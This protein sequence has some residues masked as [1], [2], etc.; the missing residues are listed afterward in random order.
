MDMHK[1]WW[2]QKIDLKIGEICG[3]K[4]AQ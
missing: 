4:D 2:E 3:V 1:S